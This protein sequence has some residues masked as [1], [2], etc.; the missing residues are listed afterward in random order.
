MKLSIYL[1]ITD[2]I[3][4]KIQSIIRGFPQRKQNYQ[5]KDIFT[6]SIINKLLISYINYTN[7]INK[8]NTLLNKKKIRLPNFPSENIVKLSI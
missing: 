1:S 8:I 2:S 4:V 3:I 7:E 6:Y 5:L